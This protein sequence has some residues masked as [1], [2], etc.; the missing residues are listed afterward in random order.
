VLDELTD[1]DGRLLHRWRDGEAAVPATAED[2]AYLLFGLIELH[3]ATLEP[4]WLRRALR[5][6]DEFDARCWDDER[7]GYYLAA[8]DADD[9]LVRQRDARD[10]AKPSA[11]GVAGWSL[12][13]LARL[14]GDTGREERALELE[15]AFA[16][17]VRQ[18]PHAHVSLLLGV[19]FR[20]GEGREVVLSGPRGEPA[21]ERMVRAVRRGYRP[22][23]MLLHR[24]ASGRGAAEM[25]DLAPFTEDQEPLDGRLTAYVCRDF[26]CREPTTDPEEMERQLGGEG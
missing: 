17:A 8:S 10:G 24:P 25:A 14:T 6:A 18:A 15:R 3:Q 19:D 5:L 21:M 11:N 23:T 1:D 13:R 12:L 2:Y 7:G 22:R 4:R 26:A 16:G 9:L 20:L